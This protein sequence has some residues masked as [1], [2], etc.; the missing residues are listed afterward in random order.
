MKV[1][2]ITFTANTRI[3]DNDNLLTPKETR[4]LIKTGF[5]GWAYLPNNSKH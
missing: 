4:K 5:V 3:Y 1:A 2:N